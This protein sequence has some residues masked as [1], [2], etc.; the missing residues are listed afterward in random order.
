MCGFLAYTNAELVWQAV[1]VAVVSC[2]IDLS[3][4]VSLRAEM[5]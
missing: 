5:N 3:A 2:R 1:R 4:L